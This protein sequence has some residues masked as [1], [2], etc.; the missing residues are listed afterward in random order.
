MRRRSILLAV[1]L[2][3]AMSQ[4]PGMLPVQAAEQSPFRVASMTTMTGKFFT[5][6][7]GMNG[8]DIDVRQLLHAYPTID[9]LPNQTQT[10][11]PVVV[12]NMKVNPDAQGNCVHQ[13]TLHEDLYFSDG[14]PIKAR[15]YVFSVLLQYS[16]YI[17]QLGGVPI[18][19][20]FLLGGRAY[21]NNATN[22]LLGVRLLDD[23]TFSITIKETAYPF[24]YD[25]AYVNVKP[26]PLH[27]IA[28]GCEVKDSAQGVYLDGPFGIALLQETILNPQT[29]YLSHPS[30]ISGPYQL[31][32][33]DSDT[34]VASF[35]TNPYYKGNANGVKPAIQRVEFQS[36][37]ADEILPA[38]EKGQIDLVNKV[39]DRQ[40]RD[41]A[42]NIAGIAHSTYNREGLAFIAFLTEQKAVHDVRVRQAIAH[43]VDKKALVEN[44]LGE[45]GKT[46]EGYY[47]IGQWMAQRSFLDEP[48]WTVYPYNI[49]M[50][51]A[52]LQKAGY[53]YNQA[54]EVYTA[55]SDTQ[56]YRKAKDGCL[57]PLILRMAITKNHQVAELL[58]TQMQEALPQ[59][60]IQLVVDRITLPEL[61]QVYYAQADRKYD[62]LF[63]A[64]NFYELFDPYYIFHTAPE[65][66]GMNAT[67]IRDEALMLAAKRMRETPSNQK[68]IYY[69]RW[70][71]FQQAFTRAL[72]MIPLYSNSYSDLYTTRLTG[73]DIQSYYSF[74]DAVIEAKL[75]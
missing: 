35:I 30:V 56:R 14:M 58:V 60:G 46:V 17:R 10:V 13:F 43:L 23:Y 49:K 6:M 4:L 24:Y 48:V 68:E 47:G 40:V 55:G 39:S 28:P 21:Q 52:L 74:A 72:P 59:A 70:I 2:A 31:T 32:A 7:W 73:Y 27:V 53:A 34:H 57:E 54:G 50:A 45:Y 26:Y 33:Y 1:I 18:Q 51:E 75:E 8:A 11:N 20:D 61:I 71:E 25:L 22:K 42:P 64:S 16:P 9:L 67:F 36:L 41:E 38:L 12:R 5:G 19:A 15:D 63:L 69:Q 37:S 66:Q 44:F 62:M 29:G 3:F 65:Y